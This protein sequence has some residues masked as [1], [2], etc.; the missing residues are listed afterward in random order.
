MADQVVIARNNK[1]ILSKGIYTG[2]SYITGKHY[3]SF[4][5]GTTKGYNSTKEIT[6]LSE[7]DTTLVNMVDLFAK[8]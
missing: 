1:G 5:D 4:F 2:Y 8:K 3:V 7:Y 6:V